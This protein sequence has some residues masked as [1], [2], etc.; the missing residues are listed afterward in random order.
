MF[1]CNSETAIRSLTSQNL[2]ERCPPEFQSTNWFLPKLFK[3]EDPEPFHHHFQPFNP[4]LSI[5]KFLLW[6]AFKFQVSSLIPSGQLSTFCFLFFRVSSLRSQ[7]SYS[8]IPHSS[9]TPSSCSEFEFGFRPSDFFRSSAFGLRISL[10][11]PPACHARRHALSR[12]LARIKSRKTPINIVN[13]TVAR[14]FYPL[15]VYPRYISASS[16]SS[17][18]SATSCSM[19][20]PTTAGLCPLVPDP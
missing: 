13:V 7:V 10:G 1:R 12:M 17:A 11:S 2:R 15:K 20:M 9:V 4:P 18:A 6:S 14:M 5:L 8:P 3:P 16:C 19:L